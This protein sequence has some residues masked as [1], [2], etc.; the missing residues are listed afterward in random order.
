[1]AALLNLGMILVSMPYSVQEL[2]TTQG[3][4][5]PYGP[6][7]LAGGDNRREIDQQEAATLPRIG[8]PVGRQWTAIANEV[9]ARP[10]LIQN[11]AER[12]LCTF[13][14]AKRG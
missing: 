4:G 1:M 14:R 13:Y 3:G 2:F 8:S 10:E 6:G 12:H 11:R 9:R 7:H 5:S